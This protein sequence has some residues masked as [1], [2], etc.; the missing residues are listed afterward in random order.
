[1]KRPFRPMLEVLEGRTTPAVSVVLDINGNL[2]GVVGTLDTA[3][4]NLLLDYNGDDL[5]EVFENGA[6]LGEYDAPG[7]VLISLG[8]S[9]LAAPSIDVEFDGF[10]MS[11]SLTLQLGN[12]LNGYAV[13]IADTDGGLIM[14]NLSITSGTGADA[15]T[16][17]NNNDVGGNVTMNLGQGSDTLLIQDGVDI[18]GS[19]TAQFVNVLDINSFG[20]DPVSIEGSVTVSATLEQPAVNDYD[21]GEQVTIGGNVSISTAFTF[22]DNVTILGDVLGNLSANLGHGANQL[23][24]ES[25]S[26]I[27][28]N[29]YIKGGY[30][31]DA[32]TFVDGGIILGNVSINLRNGANSFEFQDGA[33]VMGTAFNYVGGN[34]I[35]T[36]D[37]EGQA[38]GAYFK[39]TLA[40]GVDTV[41]LGAALS[42]ARAYIDFG[43]GA[44]VLVQNL[45]FIDFPTTLR[46]IR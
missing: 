13:N 27:Y 2:T 12:S 1:M 22:V 25:T 21:I 10:T 28:G 17:A 33:I 29:V 34:G 19:L 37:L 8:N 39:A 4:G 14:G 16:L 15:V 9:V 11:G 18:Q 45:P 24:I 44:D 32:V 35:D 41:T 40:S 3:P 7:D 38:L 31:N 30:Q 5:V 36:L 26:T 42:L 46:N 23:A 6:T 43:F 20:V